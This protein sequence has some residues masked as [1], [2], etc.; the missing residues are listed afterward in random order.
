MLPERILA[1]TLRVAGMYEALKRAKNSV[2]T[3]CANA[4]AYA[5][6]TRYLPESYD[7]RLFALRT[8][9]KALARGD[10]VERAAHWNLAQL[11]QSMEM[12][13]AGMNELSLRLE[14]LSVAM[15]HMNVAC[16]KRARSNR[17]RRAFLAYG[18]V[19]R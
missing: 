5:Q 9:A 3:L 1:Q 13:A 7:D 11:R 12:F 4:D 15:R 8:I 14:G 17:R 6:V 16:G 10:T 18:R 2:R 19:G